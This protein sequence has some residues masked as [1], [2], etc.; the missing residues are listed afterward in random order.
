[1]N[2]QSFTRFFADW[3]AEQWQRRFVLAAGKSITRLTEVFLLSKEERWRRHP[4]ITRILPR[5]LRKASPLRLD[6]WVAL[7]LNSHN[8]LVNTFCFPMWVEWLTELLH[9]DYANSLL[10]IYAYFFILFTGSLNI[11]TLFGKRAENLKFL[12]IPNKT[13][14]SIHGRNYNRGIVTVYTIRGYLVTDH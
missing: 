11:A 6:T 3:V 5:C 2:A 10:I 4:P 12:G 8:L 13:S 9:Y 7:P 14:K 1:M